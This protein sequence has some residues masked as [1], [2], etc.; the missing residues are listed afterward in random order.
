MWRHTSGHTASTFSEA[1]L[2]RAS[3]PE[4]DHWATFHWSVA[5]LPSLVSGSCAYRRPCCQRC[6][7]ARPP[8]ASALVPRGM[9]GLLA[10]SPSAGATAARRR[11]QASS[12]EVA[13]RGTTSRATKASAAPSHGRL[14][15]VAR[16]TEITR[17]DPST[18]SGTRAADSTAAGAPTM[19]I[20]CCGQVSAQASQAVHRVL[21]TSARP[22]TRRN[23]CTGQTS[24]QAPQPP[25]RVE[26]T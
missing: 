12:N 19:E 26:S 25:Q 8:G 7:C 16:G 14:P 18:V 20:A 17:A 9:G 21:S 5:G 2:A 3:R 6:W 23:A 13:T 11:S 4:G 22:F 24:T 1:Q 15:C 10:I